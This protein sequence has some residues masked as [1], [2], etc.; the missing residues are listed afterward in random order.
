MTA[1]VPGTMWPLTDRPVRLLDLSQPWNADTPPFP[2]DESPTV[3]WAKRLPSHG[4]NHQRIST[5]L[6]IGTHL[7]AP[8]HWREGGM[9]IASI[10]LDRLYGPAVVADVS[11]EFG[12]FGIIRPNDIEARVKVKPGDILII[13]TGY[14][15]YYHGGD[16]PDLV[17]YFF[18]RP[19]AD[20]ELAEWLVERQIR[21]LAVDS[22]SPDHPMNSNTRDYWPLVYQEAERVME[23][24]PADRFPLQDQTIIHRILFAHDIPIVENLSGAVAELVGRRTSVCAFPWKFAGGEAALVRVVAFI[25]P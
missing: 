17:R 23:Q 12:D 25:E 21:W 19:G 7:D 24:S 16:E 5:Q 2:L 10:P 4:T 6:H 22:S 18:K 8:L 3:V 14:H 20:R 9:D 1:V 13:R 15:R 11:D